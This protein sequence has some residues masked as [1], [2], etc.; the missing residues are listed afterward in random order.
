MFYSNYLAAKLAIWKVDIS[1]V[2]V[3][4]FR[5]KESK[6]SISLLQELVFHWKKPNNNTDT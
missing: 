3:E 5:K 1:G 4:P 2:S 6:N